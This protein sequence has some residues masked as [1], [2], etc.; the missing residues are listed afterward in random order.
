MR[1]ALEGDTGYRCYICAKGR[2]SGSSMN[3]CMCKNR[4][5]REAKNLVTERDGWDVME[6][7]E[8]LSSGIGDTW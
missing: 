6:T 1:A 3:I 8:E 5:E 7:E 2:A 4:G